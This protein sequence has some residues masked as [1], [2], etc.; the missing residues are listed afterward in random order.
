M[1]TQE[2]EN[3]TG[4]QINNPKPFELPDFNILHAIYLD[5][6]DTPLILKISNRN[7]DFYI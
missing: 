2:Q 3:N 5:L 6:I 4:H 7:I 1:G